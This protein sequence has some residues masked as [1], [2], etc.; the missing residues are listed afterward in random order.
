MY[1]R[2]QC[3]QLNKKIKIKQYLYIRDGG[4]GRGGYFVQSR[5]QCVQYYTIQ[6][7]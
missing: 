3:L 6:K 4:W 5:I 2:V 1:N 7:Y